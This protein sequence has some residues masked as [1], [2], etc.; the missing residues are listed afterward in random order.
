MSEIAMK[1]ESDNYHH[2]ETIEGI[3]KKKLAK[4]LILAKPATPKQKIYLKKQLD[5]ALKKAL[6][7]P[8]K[9]G[10]GACGRCRVL[11]DDITNKKIQ[12]LISAGLVGKPYDDPVVIHTGM[13][14]SCDIDENEQRAEIFKKELKKYY[15]DIFYLDS[16]LD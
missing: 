4:P 1:I 3:E 2:Y 10:H 7:S 12:K 13:F 11:T 14:G 9:N 16:Q 5:S 15:G 6:N 8:V